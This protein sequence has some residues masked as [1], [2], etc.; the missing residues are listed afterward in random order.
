[1][2]FKS[3]LQVYHAIYYL[4]IKNKTKKQKNICTQLQKKVGNTCYLY[5]P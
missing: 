5:L 1:M 3:R 4:A 2:S